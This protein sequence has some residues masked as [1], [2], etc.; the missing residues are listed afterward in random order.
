MRFRR[1]LTLTAR[2]VAV[3]VLLVVFTALLIGTAT[4]L[5]MRA[6]LSDQLDEELGADV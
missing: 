1:P 4:T 5:A 6:Q 2:L 3:A